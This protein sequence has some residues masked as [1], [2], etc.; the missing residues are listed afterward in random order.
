MIVGMCI[1]Y[2]ID[3]LDWQEYGEGLRS[4]LIEFGGFDF[5]DDDCIG[6]FENFKL[7]FGDFVEVMDGKFWVW[8]WVMLDDFFGKFQF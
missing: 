2:D 6:L 5:V 8:E 3:C 4:F 1:F 7:V